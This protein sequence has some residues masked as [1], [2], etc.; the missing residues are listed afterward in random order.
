MLKISVFSRTT[1]AQSG[2]RFRYFKVSNSSYSPLSDP[3]QILMVRVTNFCF[4]VLCT[5][6]DHFL[7]VGIFR[8]KL[9]LK[10]S[11]CVLFLLSYKFL[12][13]KH[14]FNLVQILILLRKKGRPV[15]TREMG[16]QPLSEY[17]DFLN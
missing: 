4:F 7:M 6:L 17:A 15:N 13:I 11:S 10:H 1:S 16:K 8:Q 3:A 12:E 14:Y 2:C 9:Q 5:V